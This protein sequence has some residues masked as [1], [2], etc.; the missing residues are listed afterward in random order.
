[1]DEFKKF[2]KDKRKNLMENVNEMNNLRFTFSESDTI[3]DILKYYLKE[4]GLDPRKINTVLQDI[5][6]TYDDY[7]LNDHE[8]LLDS[9]YILGYVH[10]KY[11]GKIFGIEFDKKRYFFIGNESEIAQYIRIGL[12]KL[13]DK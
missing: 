3:D 7:S 12:N 4:K 6:L 10:F 2:L 13:L 8:E 5:C 1:M 11:G 9:G